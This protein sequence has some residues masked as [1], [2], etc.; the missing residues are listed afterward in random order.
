MEL[1]GLVDVPD[2]EGP[3]LASG[4]NRPPGTP[5]GTEDG[6][7]VGWVAG[8]PV[9]ASALDGY[10]VQLVSSPVG[11][12]LGLGAGARPHTVDGD[13]KCR[14]GTIRTWATKALLVD[15]LLAAE[16]VRLGVAEPYSPKDWMDRLEAAGE[17]CVRTATNAEALACY[18]ANHHRYRLP[19]ARRV[20]HVL[21]ADRCSAERL[22]AG[23]DPEG[24]ADVALSESLDDGSRALGGDL[25]WVERGQL[26][27]AL[28]ETV[29]TASPGEIYGPVGSS[30]GWHV[31]LVDAVR[32]ARTRP[33]DECRA[34]ILAEL[35][36]D[37]R[38]MALREWWERRLAEAVTVPAGTEHPLSPGLPGTA[39]R[40]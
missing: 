16:A 32:P 13:D 6:T 23:T 8:T 25:G 40:H 36:H 34:E 3:A 35:D 37:R 33:F 14:A 5:E 1:L 9:R 38:L 27:G 10:V 21:L 17:L 18:R 24:L 39:H 30:F 28:E 20:R 29:F 19:E 11:A 31:L 15:R 22:V 26:A 7:V 2:Q 4:R 12:R